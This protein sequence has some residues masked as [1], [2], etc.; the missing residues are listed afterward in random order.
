MDNIEKLLSRL[1]YKADCVR[2]WTKVLE[3]QDG[4]F[5][6]RKDDDAVDDFGLYFSAMNVKGD[7]YVEHSTGNMDPADR[8]PKCV[9][10]DDHPLIMELMG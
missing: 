10:D 6:I 9:N 5:L 4:F 1:G 3:I 7:L 8:E 2:V